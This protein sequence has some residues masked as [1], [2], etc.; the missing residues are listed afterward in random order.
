M[1]YLFNVTRKGEML[2]LVFSSQPGAMPIVCDVPPL[3]PSEPYLVAY[4]CMPQVGPHR[5]PS[6]RPQLQGIPRL[7]LVHATGSRYSLAD[8]LTD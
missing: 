1:L 2:P 6:S 7:L 4:S 8:V 5:T 3:L